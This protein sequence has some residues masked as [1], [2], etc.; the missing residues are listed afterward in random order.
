MTSSFSTA[1]AGGWR[2]EAGGRRLQRAVA[3]HPQATAAA[4]RGVWQG[5]DR[6]GVSQ[7]SLPRCPRASAALETRTTTSSTSNLAVC[8]V[9]YKVLDFSPRRKGDTQGTTLLSGAGGH[10]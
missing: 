3:A 6:N 7:P 1:R 5:T 9:R 2:S 10:T 4:H 8:L